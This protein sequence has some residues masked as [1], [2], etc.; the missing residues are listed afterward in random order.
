MYPYFIKKREPAALFSAAQQEAAAPGERLRLFL[1][2]NPSFG[3]LLF[4]VTGGQGAFPIAGASVTI[5]RDLDDIHAFS[6]R[7]E[8]DESGKTAE[9]S[10][11]APAKSL[12]QTPGNGDVFA[13][14]R[15]RITAP[16]Y[17]P[18][19]VKNIPV[20]DGVTT[21]QPVNLLPDFAGRGTQAAQE[22][23]DKAPD[24]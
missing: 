19:E 3:T 20:F 23:D 4:Q 2:K 18:V 22:I 17:A 12:S 15:A 7:T 6:I 1:E 8:T 13:V 11:P 5:V 21:I 24:L 14:Y 16:D 9:F 10:L